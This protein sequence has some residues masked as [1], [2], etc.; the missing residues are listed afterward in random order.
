MTGTGLR[1]VPSSITDNFSGGVLNSNLWVIDTGSSPAPG[2]GNTG[3]FSAANIDLSQGMLA[4]KLTQTAGSPIVSVGGEVR[5]IATY[6]YGTYTCRMRASST[7]TTP[8]GAGT[9]RS[10]SDSSCFSFINNSQ[11]EIDSAEFEGQGSPGLAGCTVGTVCAEWTNFNGISNST[12]TNTVVSDADQVFH[13]YTW[14][15]TPASIVFQVDGVTVTTHTTNIPSAP[16]FV[17]FN[18]FGTN[19]ASFGGVAT[20]GVTRWQYISS[21]SYTPM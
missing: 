13:N 17:I 2:P 19:S 6:G 18:H 12:N 4:I 8:T 5:S 9:E 11:T 21:F 15:W 20:T 1:G 10:G 16:A 7:S 3:T 14:V